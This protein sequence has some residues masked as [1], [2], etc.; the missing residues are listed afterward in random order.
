MH[1]A[2]TI[3][4]QF[5][6]ASSVP[7]R[8]LLGFVT[9]VTGLLGTEQERVLTEI[10]LDEL[11]SMEAMPAPTSTQWRLVTSGAWARLAR[12]LFDVPVIGD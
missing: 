2:M 11:A 8:E 7:E 9:A 12:R 6:E 1:E 5:V 3:R 10:W 4:S